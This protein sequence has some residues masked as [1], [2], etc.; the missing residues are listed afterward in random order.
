M[1]NKNVLSL[2]Y[3]L[4]QI[5]IKKYIFLDDVCG[6]KVTCNIPLK[7]Q[8]TKIFIPYVSAENFLRCFSQSSYLLGEHMAEKKLIPISADDFRNAMANYEL[9]YRSY[10]STYHKLILKNTDFEMVLKL[11]N[12]REIKN[13]TDTILFTFT[14]ERLVISGEMS[15]AYKP[16]TN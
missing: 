8:Y 4:E 11:K 6:I 1:D 14:C 12:W 16:G 7:C 10:S 3:N 13:I 9:Y 5:F 2:I 15:F